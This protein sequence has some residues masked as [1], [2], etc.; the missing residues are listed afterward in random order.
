MMQKKILTVMT[1]ACLA[2]FSLASPV[3]AEKGGKGN[4]PKTQHSHV[5][6]EVKSGFC[7]PGLAKKNPPC[8]PPGQA[9]KSG[10][11]THD[12][13]RIGDVIDRDDWVLIRNPRDY[14]LYD[15]PY[16]RYGDHVYRINSDTGRIL[17]VIGL[18]DAL[19]N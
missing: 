9:K 8:I 19:L 6:T 14:G 16:V 7:P 11:V 12:H 5:I 18:I 17:S 3:L 1:I 13:L 15:G 2:G 4:A 10:A